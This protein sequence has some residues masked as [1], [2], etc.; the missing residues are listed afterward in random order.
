MA[1]DPEIPFRVHEFLTSQR[2]KLQEEVFA[3]LTGGEGSGNPKPRRRRVGNSSNNASARGGAGSPAARG[4]GAFFSLAT[5]EQ[6]EIPVGKRAFLESEL[7]QLRVQSSDLAEK[8]SL[9]EE[10]ARFL[11]G[12]VV[13]HH[14]HG[15]GLIELGRVVDPSQAAVVEVKDAAKEATE[16]EVS[17]EASMPNW[18]KLSKGERKEALKKAKK[19]AKGKKKKEKEERKNREEETMDVTLFATFPD[20]QVASLKSHSTSYLYLYL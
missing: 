19:E 9:V 16:D 6:E 2:P 17:L 14:S 8:S 7:S 13:W 1:T 12:S 10:R 15:Q 3:L 5:P 4:Y 11:P 20:A 18:D